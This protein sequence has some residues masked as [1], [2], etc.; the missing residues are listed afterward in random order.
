MKTKN[1]DELSRRLLS[2]KQINRA[3]IRAQMMIEI[4]EKIKKAME[5]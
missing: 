4:S 2:E 1:F 5:K 3:K